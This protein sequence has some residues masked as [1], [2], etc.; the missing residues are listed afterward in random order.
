MLKALLISALLLMG[1][2]TDRVA[3]FI[4]PRVGNA[5]LKVK[6][7]FTIPQSNDNREYCL[8]WDSDGGQAGESCDTLDLGEGEHYRHTLTTILRYPGHYEFLLRVRQ[9][10]KILSSNQISVEVNE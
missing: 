1:P 3:L 7:E 5:P 4:S 10:D 8:V 6:A 9:V 2:P